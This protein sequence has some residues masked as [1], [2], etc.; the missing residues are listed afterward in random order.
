MLHISRGNRRTFRV[1]QDRP[2]RNTPTVGEIGVPQ[3]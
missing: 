2:A 1:N 3:I